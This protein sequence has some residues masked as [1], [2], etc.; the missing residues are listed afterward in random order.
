MQ[1]S[2]GFDVLACPRCPGRLRLIALIEQRTVVR[3][4]LAHLG[5]PCDILVPCPS[6]APPLTGVALGD[7]QVL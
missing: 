3:R 6:R 4:I 1:R 5:L 7:N 2:L